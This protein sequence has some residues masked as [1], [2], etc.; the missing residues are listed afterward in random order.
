MV[1]SMIQ[2]GR[3]KK[4]PDT[5]KKKRNIYT[6][7]KTPSAQILVFIGDAVFLY[8]PPVEGATLTVWEADS[9]GL[10][11]LNK[12]GSKQRLDNFGF[13][14]RKKQAVCIIYIEVFSDRYCVWYLD[15]GDVM[16]RGNG[17]EKYL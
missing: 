5:D 8:Q 6:L 13:A 10:G 16:P 3:Q 11:K 2:K 14:S 15:I 1:T 12:S 4:Y 7:F 9:E 17:I